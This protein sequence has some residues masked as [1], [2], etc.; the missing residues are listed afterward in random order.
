MIKSGSKLSAAF[1][2]AVAKTGKYYDTNGL[3]LRVMPSGSKQWVQR[4]VIHGKRRDIG[5]GGYPLVTLAEARQQTFD[6]RKLARAGGDPLALKCRPE[7]PTFEE[8][9]DTV[10][11]LH[12]ATW[13]D[14]GKSSK[15][16]RASLRDYAMPRLGRRRDRYDHFSGRDGRLVADLE[17]QTRNRPAC[18]PTHRRGVQMGHRPRISEG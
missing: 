12:A 9:V 1:V 13:K 3:I 4:L 16:W 5:L 7:V 2:R 10:I 14:S 17:R 6:N 11:E 8:A 15:Q 18:S